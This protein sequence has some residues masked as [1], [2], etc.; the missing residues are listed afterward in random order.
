MSSTRS[1]NGHVRRK[2]ELPKGV[3]F[4]RKRLATGE[5]IRY[6]YYGRGPGAQALGREGSAEFH[7]RLAEVI[8]H[9]PEPGRVFEL[10]HRYKTSREF[11]KLR[12]RT[13]A[14]YRRH[15]DKIQL[16]FGK[17][18]IAAMAAPQVA[19][20]IYAWRDKL[21]DS[22]P[23]QAD[24]SIS[25]LAAMLAW[26]VKR[27]LINHNRAAGV[28]D[29]YTADRSEKIWTPEQQAAF[30]KVAPEPVARAFML[31]IETGLAQEDCLALSWSAVNHGVIVARRL[32]NGT[33]VAIPIS[34]DLQRVFD[35]GPRGDAVTILTHGGGN[36]WDPKGN[37]LRAAFHD[38]KKA[39]GIDGLTFHDTR[40][41]FITRRRA[42]GWTAEEVALCS[43]HK[44]AGELGAQASYAHRAEIALANARRLAVRYYSLRPDGDLATGRPAGEAGGRA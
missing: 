26:S 34:P 1:G 16:K 4:Q 3:W 15:L 17:L 28:G 19:E 18:R 11:A 9:Q 39:A 44:I 38:A 14:D 12:P 25:V 10:I 21:A 41:T 13:Q 6:G 5:V 8:S 33:P 31:A 23:R 36:S 37:S 30:L 40:G 22:S 43:G 35:A 29:A 32:K 24:Y 2:T 27:G 7:T 20:H 42:I